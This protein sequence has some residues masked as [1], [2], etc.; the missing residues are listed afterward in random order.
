MIPP[1]CVI[2]R[3]RD[4]I[5]R[6]PLNEE[7]WFGY[8]EETKRINLLRQRCCRTTLRCA[9]RSWIELHFTVLHCNALHD[10]EEWPELNWTGMNWSWMLFTRCA[11]VRFFVRFFVRCFVVYSGLTA[12]Y[13]DEKCYHEFICNH[14]GSRNAFTAHEASGF[15]S[16]CRVGSTHEDE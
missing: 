12:K 10:T 5:L 6:L 1:W 3:L 16:C 13:P 4:D 14:G 7:K 9:A 11:F 2:Y 8:D 15:I